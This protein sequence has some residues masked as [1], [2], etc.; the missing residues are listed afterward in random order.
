M[1]PGPLTHPLFTHTGVSLIFCLF[2][3]IISGLCGLHLSDSL[4][5][6]D[7]TFSRG[8]I[9]QK[10]WKDLYGC[11]GHEQDHASQEHL[12]L[13]LMLVTFIE[14]GFGMQDLDL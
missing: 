3:S 6:I 13:L 8:L 14:V 5:N 2:S 11:T 12:I 7:C 4:I 1:P 10:K 9:R